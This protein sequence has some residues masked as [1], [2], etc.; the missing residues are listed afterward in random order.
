MLI[1]KSSVNTFL[2]RL[3]NE[4]LSISI[5]FVKEFEYIL[6]SIVYQEYFQYVLYLETHSPNNRDESALI[7]QSRCWRT[8]LKTNSYSTNILGKKIEKYCQLCFIHNQQTLLTQ[9]ICVSDIYKNDAFLDLRC[10]QSH[11]W[12]NR[13]IEVDN[14]CNNINRRSQTTQIIYI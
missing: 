7:R 1:M 13:L 5:H 6:V 10:T 4:L 14:I 12:G 11:V 8:P 2:F 3:E 9:V